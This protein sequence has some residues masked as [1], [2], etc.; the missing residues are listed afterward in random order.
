LLDRFGLFSALTLPVSGF[1][2]AESLSHEQVARSIQEAKA[3]Q[4]KRFT[5]KARRNGDLLSI[6]AHP[7]FTLDSEVH[8]WLTDTVTKERLSFRRKA[9][10]IRVA[11]TIADLAGKNRIETAHLLE[12]WSFRCPESFRSPFVL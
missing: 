9:Q 12:A 5:H 2:S 10:L 3:I 4:E 8:A 11:R 6:D 7:D 1:R